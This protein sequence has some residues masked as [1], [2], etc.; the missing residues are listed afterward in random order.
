MTENSSSQLA[1]N[2]RESLGTCQSH[3]LSYRDRTSS[4][5]YLF[6]PL[7]NL[8]SQ[9]ASITGFVVLDYTK[10]YPEGVKDLGQW[11]REGKLKARTHVEDGP[12][13]RCPEALGRLFQGANTGKM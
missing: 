13:E 4:L 7:R 2:R 8:I 1:V 9:R 3:I 12:V 6:G 11:I 5:T 10:R